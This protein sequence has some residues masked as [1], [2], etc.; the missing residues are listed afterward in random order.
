MCTQPNNDTLHAESLAGGSLARKTEKGTKRTLRWEVDLDLECDH[1]VNPS[2]SY[3]LVVRE[4]IMEEEASPAVQHDSQGLGEYA[5]ED[6]R[7]VIARCSRLCTAACGVCT[8]LLKG[9]LTKGHPKCL[10]N[11]EKLVSGGRGAPPI[12]ARLCLTTR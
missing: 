1:S 7:W 9:R 6:L 5:A 10:L 11:D 12:F 8:L 4:G 3:I 2:S